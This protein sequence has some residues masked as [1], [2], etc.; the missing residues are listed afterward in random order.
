MKGYYRLVIEQLRAN[1]YTFLNRNPH[2]TRKTTMDV[3]SFANLKVN[4]AHY[5]DK[6]DNDHMPVVITHQNDRKAV[7]IGYEDY[8]SF[9]G[10]NYL[11]SNPVNAER[12]NKGIDEVEAG[13]T[14]KH[15]LIEA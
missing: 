1:G 7:L 14:R 8:L 2:E 3:V 6:L 12:I 4:L 15:E 10:T 13:L 5:L 11:M 9:V